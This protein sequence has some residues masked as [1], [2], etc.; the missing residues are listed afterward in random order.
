[1]RLRALGIATLLIGM[2]LLFFI[3]CSAEIRETDP[4]QQK[5]LQ[6][7]VGNEPLYEVEE[8][9]KFYE[10]RTG[11]INWTPAQ[12]N[13]MI[14]A[15][16][17]AKTRGL[18]SNN[19]HWKAIQLSNDA[20]KTIDQ[21]LLLSD[22]FLRLAH[23]LKNGKA[24]P[25]VSWNMERAPV[26]AVD[27]LEHALTS[28]NI[29]MALY[30]VEPQNLQYQIMIE[31]LRNYRQIAS[32]GGWVQLP[33]GP[34]LLKGSISLNVGGLRHRLK[35]SGEYYGE[36]S[37]D[38]LFD[39]FLDQAVRRFQQTHGLNTDGIV[40]RSTLDELNVP[41]EKRIQ[42]IEVNLERMR[43]IADDLGERHIRINIPAFELT[44]FIKNSEW[45][46]MR[47]IVGKADWRSPVFLS[48]EI[49]YLETN[50][51]WYV[52][53]VIAQ[54]EIWPKVA[55]NQDYLKKNRLK[56]IKRADGG[57]M[58]RQIPGPQNSLGRIKIHFENNFDCYL[59]DTPEKHL[60]DKV[61]R[62][63]SHG[64]IRLENA[65][66]LSEYLLIGDSEWDRQKLED[67]IENDLQKKIYLAE[68]IPISFVYL[69]TWPDK[70]GVVQFRK[71]VYEM[72]GLLERELQ[73]N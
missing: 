50:P 10:R 13:E 47:V 70:F 68:S 42:Q 7:K 63:F 55:K 6:H 60:F 32:S 39:D 45:L 64:C 14:Q 4:I 73:R 25:P 53:S 22:A 72:D 56:I 44:A 20:I 23:H 8:L 43:W 34:K 18:N 65:L 31:T 38:S 5:L 62:A 59:H 24:K 15:I 36:A 69:T 54:K 2:V 37:E 3:T 1:M 26:D 30:S 12:A 21:D 66:D 51:F 58:L 35:I 27:L 71:D 49:T 11:K 33:N 9:S 40:G 28:N 16:N 41:I 52:P 19:Y 17:S 67:A 57:T 46:T 61:D 29:S 48:S